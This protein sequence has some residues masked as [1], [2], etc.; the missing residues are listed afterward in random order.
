MIP[1][2]QIRILPEF[3]GYTVDARL[4]EFRKLGKGRFD[5]LPFSSEEGDA[6]LCMYLKTLDIRSLEFQEIADGV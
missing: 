3:Q 5:V 2:N 6:L 4:R 1:K